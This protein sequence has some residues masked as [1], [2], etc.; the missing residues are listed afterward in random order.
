M[1]KIGLSPA[2]LIESQQA[3][4]SITKP[5]KDV[6][7]ST[8]KAQETA[9]ENPA[10]FTTNIHG[11]AQNMA[12]K[13][14]VGICAVGLKSFFALTARYNEVLRTGSVYEQERLRSEVEIAGKKYR[15]L[16]NAYG[17]NISNEAIAKVVSELSN[18]DQALVLSGL[19]SLATD[20]AKELALDKLNASNMLGMYIYGITIG[21]DFK[22]LAD[23]ICSETGLIINEMMRGNSFLNEKGMNVQNIFDYLETAPYLS[24][25]VNLTTGSDIILKLNQQALYDLTHS[26]LTVE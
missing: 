3:M 10:N 21:V 24:T 12:G 4:D 15:M 1:Y 23:I 20:N 26:G 13:K 5:L 22:T 8:I 17:T 16:A 14:G 9:L 7:N 6:A 18:Q 2:N 25:N 19:L 11:I